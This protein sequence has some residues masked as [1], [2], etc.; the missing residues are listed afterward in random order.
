MMGRQ[1]QALRMLNELQK[2]HKG[3]KLSKSVDK[4]SESLKNGKQ[5][6]LKIKLHLAKESALIAIGKGIKSEFLPN[7]KNIDLKTN[8][9]SLVFKKA[10][11]SLATSPEATHDLCSLILGYFPG[12]LASLQLKGEALAALKQNDEAT[13]IWR[14]LVSSGNAK[15]SQK[16]TELIA[17]NL[18]ARAEIVS[19]TKSPKAALSFFIKQHFML[20]LAPMLNQEIS[21]ILSK[22]ERLRSEPLDPE[23][24]KH[25]LQLI[26]N[27]LVIEH[28]ENHWRDKG[29]LFATAAVQKPGTIGKTAPTTG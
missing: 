7:S 8:I 10:R 15:I 27:T 28:L 9:K 2:E 12:D 20:N 24:E 17:K 13:R 29:L 25:Q 21:K 26:F 16:A 6:Q 5:N 14:E 1:K 4:K 11:A 3:E 19:K 23:L 22:S 18:A